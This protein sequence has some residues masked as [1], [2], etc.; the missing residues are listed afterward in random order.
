M[1]FDGPDSEPRVGYSMLLAIAPTEQEAQD[2]ARRGMEGLVR[3]TR[4]AHRFDHLKV[5][6]DEAYAA[7]APLRAIHANMDI[8]IQFGAGTPGQIA[9]RVAMLLDDGMADYI[10]FMMPTGDMTFDEAKRTL[11]LFVTEVQPQLE[12]PAATRG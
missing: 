9:E 12:S 5:S 4:A 8:A 3:R 7:Q 6:E 1:R 2:V 10:C 11:E